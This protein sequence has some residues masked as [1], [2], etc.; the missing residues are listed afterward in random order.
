MRAP[1]CT[2]PASTMPTSGSSQNRHGGGSGIPPVGGTIDV[3]LAGQPQQAGFYSFQV[4]RGQ[5]AERA[6]PNQR[7]LARSK[8]DR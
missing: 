3:S 5:R 7:R 8:I 1:C 4:P 6:P 2:T